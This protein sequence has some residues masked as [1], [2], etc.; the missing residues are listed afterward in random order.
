MKENR[1]KVH[2]RIPIDDDR[3]D[4]VEAFARDVRI[5]L[6]K[7]PKSLPCIYFYDSVGS[8]FFEWI[9]RQPEY[10]CTRAEAEILQK[11]AGDIAACFS[12]RIP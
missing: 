12:G 7:S 8:R 11:H 6:S 10:Y 3:I 1:Q 5:G 2:N 4:T 9:C